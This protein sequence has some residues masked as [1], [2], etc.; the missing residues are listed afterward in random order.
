[1]VLIVIFSELYLLLNM[2]KKQPKQY[3]AV[4]AESVDEGDTLKYFNRPML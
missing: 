4:V 2:H 3:P 1:M